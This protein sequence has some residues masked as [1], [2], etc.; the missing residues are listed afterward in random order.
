MLLEISGEKTPERTKRRNQSKNSTQLW[1]WLV[2][3]VKSDAVSTW[4][5]KSMNQGKFEAIKQEMAR[6]NINI[7]GINELK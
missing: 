3:E 4:N 5:V 6:L 2:M 7:L 1:I